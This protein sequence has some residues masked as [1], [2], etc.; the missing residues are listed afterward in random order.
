MFLNQYEKQRL[1]E[2]LEKHDL[3][4]E[5]LYVQNDDNSIRNIIPFDPVINL[6]LNS[7]PEEIRKVYKMIMKNPHNQEHVTLTLASVYYQIMDLD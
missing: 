7:E 3:F 5:T 6:V 1:K 4:G 2:I